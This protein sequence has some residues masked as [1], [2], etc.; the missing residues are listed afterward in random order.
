VFHTDSHRLL[1]L[2]LHLARLNPSPLCPCSFGQ[3]QPACF[4]HFRVLMTEI[5]NLWVFAGQ[6]LIGLLLLLLVVL[7][8]C[9]DV[10]RVL[11]CPLNDVYLSPC[12]LLVR[13]MHP[14]RGLYRSLLHLFLV[15]QCRGHA[16]C[17]SCRSASGLLR[18]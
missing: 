10:V 6:C 15:E 2:H 9:L 12:H 11:V 16:A 1:S 7:T 5:Y 13:C 8:A 4:L 3:V 14:Q 18:L 17:Y